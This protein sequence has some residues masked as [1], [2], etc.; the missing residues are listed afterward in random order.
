MP[1]APRTVG[2]GLSWRPR[3]DTKGTSAADGHALHEDGAMSVRVE[4]VELVTSEG[5]FSAD[6]VGSA[7]APCV[8]LL[9]GFPQSRHT[10]HR[11][12]PALF[13]AGFHAIALDQRGYSPGVRPTGV[14]PYVTKRLV[15]D[16]IDIVE[17]LGAPRA[18]LVGHDWGGQVAWMAAAH[19]PGRV[20]S[21][22]VLSRPHPAAFARAFDVD[23]EQA[24]RS[25]HHR[26]FQSAEITDVLWRDGCAALRAALSD[27]GVPEADITAYLSVFSDRAALDAAL[28]WY[29]A[30]GGDGLGVVECPHVGVPTLYLWGADDSS[31]GRVAAELTAEHV[32][33]P[34]RFVEV[35]A[36]GHFLT[37]DGGGST[38]VSELLAHLA[39]S[40]A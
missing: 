37:D 25:A 14:G 22:S 3:S 31:V 39:R 32:S 17:T 15:D 21:L 20:A 23:P 33:G 24:S 5:Q 36:S 12:L 27:G 26:T 6:T 40:S 13:K 11:V 19:H 28:N 18:H 1:I 29:R 4:S 38:V 7:D 8:L 2:P 30:A 35:P 10:W 34:Y 9:H 16:V